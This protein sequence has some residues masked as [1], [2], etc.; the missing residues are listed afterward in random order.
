MPAPTPIGSAVEIVLSQSATP[1]AQSV[2]GGVPSDAQGVLVF[3][4][5]L[6]T[7][8]SIAASFAGTFTTFASADGEPATISAAIVNSTG[9]GTVTPTW[10]SA[11]SEGPV[12]MV[13]FVK[14]IDTSN[15]DWVNDFDF[16]W[17]G[18]PTAATATVPSTADQ[19][20][21]A[22]D[23]KYGFGSPPGLASGWTS[24][25]TTADGW[26]RNG[27]SGRLSYANTPG[28]P[29]TTF[30]SQDTDFS[31]VGLISLIG[32]SG[33]S[34]TGT[35]TESA[36]GA[37]SQTRSLQASR[38]QAESS[39]GADTQSASLTAARS[40]TESSA[41]SD[42][43][44]SSAPIPAAMAE[45]SA[46]ADAQTQTTTASRA[47]AESSASADT[48]AS[49]M[50]ASRAQAESSA[51]ADSQNRTMV[52]TSAQTESSA[53]ADAQTR[54]M[55]ATATQT[56][57]SAGADLTSGAANGEITIVESAI[58]GDS[59]NRSMTA[60]RSQAETAASSDTH[61]AVLAK[62]AAMQEAV[63]GL[64][65]QTA[66]LVAVAT[67]NEAAAGADMS[68]GFQANATTIVEFVSPADVIT[69]ALVAAGFQ[70]ETQTAT[71]AQART[72]IAIAAQAESQVPTDRQIVEGAPALVVVQAEDCTPL[73]VI[74]VLP[75][76]NGVNR[77]VVRRLPESYVVKGTARRFIVPR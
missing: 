32:T 21:I 53:G 43:T 76:T 44:S 63:A 8:N 61:A 55:S 14:D 18:G 60:S 68:I 24:L 57:S 67:L 26:E 54:T 17:N 62:F 50:T 7:L 3:T 27:N 22:W 75:P 16:G 69:S 34:F 11:V 30:N 2:P 40:Q 77:F 70:V 46:G 13:L 5:A 42:S 35:Q 25:G 9:A 71:D 58:S 48:N 20:V 6:A 56:E 51:G 66:V 31:Q 41:G 59:S 39:A 49:S 73:D 52:A 47:Q 12:M 4:R 19:L 23:T 29:T 15:M 36:A 1:G 33:G 38:A 37:D 28:D 72:M 10:A 64:D 74:E 45:S 65:A